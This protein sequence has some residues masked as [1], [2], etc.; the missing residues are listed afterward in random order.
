MPPILALQDATVGLGRTALFESVAAAVEPGARI[1]LVGRNGSG[2]STLLRALA[3]EVELDHGERFLQPGAAVA[4]L[5]QEPDLGPELTALDAVTG[6]LPPHVDPG[7]AT[8]QAGRLLEQLEVAPEAIIGTLSGGE[9]R[10]VAI[11]R[12]LGADADVLLLDEPTNH[13]DIPTIEALEARLKEFAGAIVVV[14]HD[15][16]FLRA[17]SRTTWWLDRGALR[18]NDQGFAAFDDWSD[19]VLAA[20]EQAARRL[21]KRIRQENAW[22]SFGV[23]ARRKR[24]QGR[25]RRLHELRAARAARVRPEGQVRFERIEAGQGARMIVEAEGLTKRLGERTLIDG[26][27]TRILRGDRVGLVGRNGAGKTTLL[28]LL[29][30]ELAPDEGR[31]RRMDGLRTA[32]IDQRRA[33]LDPETTP[34]ATLCPDG[35]DQVQVQGRSRHVVGYL[36][37]FLFRPEQVRAPVH[38]LS[39]GE[40]NRL[41]LARELA[42]PADL[43][44]LDEP[45]NDLDVETLDLL[46]EVL[47]DFD[48][49]VLLV[50]H[51]RDFLDR[52]VTSV[53]AFEGRGRLVEYAGGYS[54]M[55]RQRRAEAPAST[56][57]PARSRSGPKE[58]AR[59]P[60][61]ERELERVM[62]RIEQ[63][64]AELAA[65]EDEL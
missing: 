54:D 52:L 7:R 32:Y 45:T 51:D 27:S 49:S 64:E 57:K 61:P 15:R 2:K 12:A 26:F 36:E 37:D 19:Q 56:A 29:S 25:L 43:L 14:S 62:Q 38:S 28:R 60:R 33:G 31:V 4:Y 17:L 6:G 53:I 30:G 58:R 21:D 40:R 16:A 39:G 41:L 47:S 18:I 1:C 11:A 63:L 13:L 48:G 8:H 34:W 35:G 44:I 20:E 42:R 50:S 3:G 9:H 24:N 22:L 10:R 55:L 65:V 46:Q 23:T 59:A 5:A